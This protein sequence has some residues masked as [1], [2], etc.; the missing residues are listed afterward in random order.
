[1]EILVPADCA[2]A[3]DLF[4]APR[5]RLSLDALIAGNSPGTLW[6]DDPAAPRS[7][8]MWDG[9]GSVALAGDAN[10]AAFLQEA[11][12]LIAE[13]VLP[14]HRSLKI[15]YGHPGWEGAM[16]ALFPGAT[17]SVGARVLYSFGRVALPD[18]RSRVPEGFAIRAV[19]EALLAAD[20][21]ANIGRLRAEVAAHWPSVER[22][23]ARGLGYCALRGDEVAGWCDGGL[24]SPGK[25]SITIETMERYR[26]LGLAT[27]MASAFLERCQREGIAPYW[28]AWAD[29]W[30]SLATAE[31]VG[32]ARIDAYAIRVYGPP[33]APQP[34]E[35]TPRGI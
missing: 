32:L 26:R 6:V 33:R 19:D 18:W 14:R 8:L 1:M 16:A 7:A 27:L 34:S 5:L 11:A 10:N 15:R 22:Y 35:R 20:G 25:T 21:L 29:N 9:D 12:A 30:G 3:R 2:R 24:A 13:R 31:R 23:L 17:L 4:A 28:D